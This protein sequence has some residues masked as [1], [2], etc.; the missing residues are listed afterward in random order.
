ML[1]L[2][3]QGHLIRFNYESNLLTCLQEDCFFHYPSEFTRIPQNI[4][5][6]GI[7]YIYEYAE[8][9]LKKYRKHICGWHNRK[10]F[11]KKSDDTLSLVAHCNRCGN[12]EVIASIK[13]K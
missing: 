9:Q 7:Y 6:L 4:A 5:N 13:I 8:E 10:F 2:C 1:R 11:T 12:D 3:E